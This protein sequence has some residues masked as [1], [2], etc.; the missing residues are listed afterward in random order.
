MHLPLFSDLSKHD[1]SARSGLRTGAITL[2]LALFAVLF[3]SHYLVVQ[4]LGTLHVLAPEPSP[5]RYVTVITSKFVI[6]DRCGFMEISPHQM[7]LT[8][9]YD[10]LCEIEDKSEYKARYTAISRPL[11]GLQAMLLIKSEQIPS[12]RERVRAEIWTD[13]EADRDDQ[14]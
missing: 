4:H 5:V 13:T 1:H 2:A 3:L 10:E 8:A 9:L 6:K 7:P 12:S 14:A 11:C